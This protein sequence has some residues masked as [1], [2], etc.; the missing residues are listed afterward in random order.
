[1]IKEKLYLTH[2]RLN[3]INR[4][5]DKKEG[6]KS[7]KIGFAKLSL[8][9]TTCDFINRHKPN[10]V[11][12]IG[13]L[14]KSLVFNQNSPTLLVKPNMTIL[15]NFESLS[16]I[17]MRN[18]IRPV[19]TTKMI[20][21]DDIFYMDFDDFVKQLK[22]KAKRRVIKDFDNNSPPNSAQRKKLKNSTMKS[23]VINEDFTR[24]SKSRIQ[25]VKIENP[26]Q[27]I[28]ENEENSGTQPN[29]GLNN[30]NENE[31]STERN[32]NFLLI[33]NEKFLRAKSKIS[34]FSPNYPSLSKNVG[35]A[36]SNKV[37]SLSKRLDKEDSVKMYKKSLS[38]DID[39]EEVK[40][41][42]PRSFENFLIEKMDFCDNESGSV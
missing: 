31:E 13:K 29:R 15:N 14:Q 27:P 1:M 34:T 30:F 42:Q 37:F 20:V 3:M 12:S 5:I 4:K 36:R 33:E 21:N 10:L 18:C 7:L 35:K 6:K 9:V 24:S 38:L 8:K 25:T 41:N 2:Q 22:K 26:L 32:E 16:A 40:R 28:K 19:K 23:I 11:I 39:T 17:S